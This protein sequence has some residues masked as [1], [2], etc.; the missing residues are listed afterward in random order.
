MQ[1]IPMGH[2]ACCLQLTMASRKSCDCCSRLELTKMIKNATS[3]HGETAWLLAA[4][5]SHLVV[6]RL[7]LEAGADKDA[8]NTERATALLLAAH[9]SHLKV[10]R[11]L[12]EAGADKDAATTKESTAL[13]LAVQNGDFEVV[14][15][16][17]DAGAD[18]DATVFNSRLRLRLTAL[19][20]AAEK[21]DWAVVRSRLALTS[22]MEQFFCC[23]QP[24]AA[25]GKL[26]ACCLR[27][28][29]T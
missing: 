6:V 12:L 4:Q 20:I 17:L 14:R 7:L 23:L 22:D 1:Q 15:L 2:L 5:K 26:C 16:L 24:G 10:V 27:L 19:M 25:I 9:N 21:S 29:V 11:L 8:S 18:K 3:A 13:L 28:E